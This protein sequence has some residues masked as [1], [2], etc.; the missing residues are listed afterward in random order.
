MDQDLDPL[1]V[2]YYSKTHKSSGEN[3]LTQ[4]I[5]LN[6]PMHIIVRFAKTLFIWSVDFK[7]TICFITTMI[8]KCHLPIQQVHVSQHCGINVALQKCRLGFCTLLKLTY[9]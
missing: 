3:Y 4:V 5:T 9:I 8:A 6:T 7:S 1:K 2:K